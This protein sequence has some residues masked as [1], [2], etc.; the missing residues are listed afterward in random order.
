MS[1]QWLAG[2]T[3]DKGSRQHMR[4]I[5]SPY[6]ATTLN[7]ELRF[8]RD[9][10]SV[11][12]STTSAGRVSLSPRERSVLDLIG[13]GD[14]NKEIARQGPVWLRITRRPHTMRQLAHGN[15]RDLA[16]IVGAENEDLISAADRDKANVP[17]A[18]RTILTWFV[19]GPVSSVFNSA[20]GGLASSKT[21]VLP[22]SFKVNHTCEPSGV[23]AMF[24]QNGLACASLATT[25]W[26][27]TD[28]TSVSGLKDEQT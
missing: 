17:R 25:R 24:G 21:C 15:R 6:P 1:A 27:A 3:R 16:E 7:D 26:S 8:G 13:Q 18:L 5:V 14:T 20:N 9:N 22:V 28:T 4:Y 10:H 12:V 2:M 11:Q 23:A 19:I